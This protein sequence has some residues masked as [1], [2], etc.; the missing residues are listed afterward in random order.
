MCVVRHSVAIRD[1]EN[2]LC[3]AV[4]AH[5]G[6]P[7]PAVS[8]SQVQDALIRV[9]GIPQGAF[10]VHWYRPEDFLIVL[11]TVELRDRVTTRTSLEYGGFS[12]FF[13]KW[14]RFAQATSESWGSRVQLVIEG[15]LTH[16]W[17]REV[18]EDLLGTSCSN[19]E[20]APAT[21]PRRNLDMCSLSAWM[22][23][24]NR[25]PTARTLAVPE[26]EEAADSTPSPAR[27]FSDDSAATV[28]APEQ[29]ELKLLKYK[30][31]IHVDRVEEDEDP[32]D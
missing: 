13:K 10:T 8:C 20:V 22:A 17:D 14:T 7:R 26:P 19:E 16:A 4:V 5:V 24:E 18:V 31:L 25:I 3:Y 12:L 1:L 23:N 9:L 21:T 27:E 15:I 2:M 30:G 28:N 11:R 29:R 6:G 32:E